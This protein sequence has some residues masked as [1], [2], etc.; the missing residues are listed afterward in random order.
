M[1]GEHEYY[2]KFGSSKIENKT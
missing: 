1:Y 2:L